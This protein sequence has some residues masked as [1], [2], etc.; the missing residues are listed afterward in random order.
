MCMPKKGSLLCVDLEILNIEFSFHKWY[1]IFVPKRLPT[2][3]SR[4]FK[5]D[6]AVELQLKGMGYFIFSTPE[7]FC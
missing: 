4:C 2:S 6:A 3:N 7:Y 1:G 5:A